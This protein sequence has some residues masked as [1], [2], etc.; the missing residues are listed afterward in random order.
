MRILVV[1][2]SACLAA[3]SAF[4]ADEPTHNDLAEMNATLK[5]I[6][7]ALKQQLETQKGD[8]LLK[9]MTFAATQ[10]TN[11][12]ERL[13]SIDRAAA[14]LDK[15]RLELESMLAAAQ[16]EAQPGDGAPARLKSQWQA[17]QD[18]LNALRQERIG[19]ENDIQSLRREVRDWQTLLD[20]T[21][22]S[23]S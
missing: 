17:V 14:T 16:K 7:R 5:E 2:F 11:A 15:D 12:Q 20:K 19:V 10:L 22:T 8:L 23:G 9:R 1:V 6:A 13:N 18:R 21:L 3:S 4:A